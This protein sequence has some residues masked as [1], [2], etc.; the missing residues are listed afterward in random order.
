MTQ[1]FANHGFDV[2]G[3]TTLDKW[4]QKNV[5]K[6]GANRAEKSNPKGRSSQCE[7]GDSHDREGG[8]EGGGEEESNH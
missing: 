1:T 5:S 6:S 8:S 3:Q 2:Y 4:K 7:F